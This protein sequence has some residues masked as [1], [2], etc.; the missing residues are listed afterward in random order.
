MTS[1]V[2]LIFFCLL[3]IF[4]N[5]HTLNPQLISEVINGDFNSF[6][7]QNIFFKDFFVLGVEHILTGWDHLAFL[8]GLMLIFRRLNLL[9]AVT[10][11][12]VGHSISLAMASLGLI[13]I[14]PAWIEALIGFSVAL[15]AIEAAFKYHFEFRNL[16]KISIIGI[17]FFGT[18]LLLN[19][20]DFITFFSM[21]LLTISYLYLSNYGSNNRSSFLLVILFGLIHGFGFSTNLQ[22]YDLLQNDFL[23]SLF[24]FNLGVEIGQ[25]LMIGIA[26]I[27]V[28]IS[29]RQL[30]ISHIRLAKV[31]SISSLLF[32][33]IFWFSYR[34]LMI[35]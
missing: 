34:T 20:I 35:M 7:N 3:S 12:T 22:E 10:C 1:K 9:I 26:L 15:V 13:A 11:F 19:K 27:I 8:V 29:Q 31:M 30:S 23:K 5:T 2:F 18:F 17:C 25:L 32:L 24:G 4:V 33:G 21:F 16:K 6:E 14:N 28:A